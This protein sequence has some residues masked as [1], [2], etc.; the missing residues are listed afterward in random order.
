MCPFLLERSSRKGKINTYD[1]GKKGKNNLSVIL[2]WERRNGV[3]VPQLGAWPQ[4]ELSQGGHQ[5]RQV[6]GQLENVPFFQAG[7]GFLWRKEEHF[8][9]GGAQ[10]LSY[11]QR[12]H[13]PQ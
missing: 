4:L 9:K 3:L 7:G 1:A 10:P 5:V 12:S 13:V 2:E 8:S 11:E 6:L